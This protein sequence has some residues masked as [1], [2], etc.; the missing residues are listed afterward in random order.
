MFKER[1][2]VPPGQSNTGTGNLLQ[3][4]D[5]GSKVRTPPSRVLNGPL[6]SFFDRRKGFSL[7]KRFHFSRKPN[8]Y[9]KYEYS[10]NSYQAYNFDE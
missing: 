4:T 9:L 2:S 7:S 6:E 10:D 5:G 1:L 3:G 8:E